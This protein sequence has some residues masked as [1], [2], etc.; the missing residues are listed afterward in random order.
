MI[1]IILKV[2]FLF[3]STLFISVNSAKLYSKS[4]IP[5]SNFVLMSI[6]IVGFISI[7]YII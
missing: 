7:T 5:S 2:L 1:L 3:M 4:D 6:G